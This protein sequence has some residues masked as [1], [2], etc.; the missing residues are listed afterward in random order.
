MERQPVEKITVEQVSIRVMSMEKTWGVRFAFTLEAPRSLASLAPFIVWLRIANPY[1]KAEIHWWN[2]MLC[3][4]EP[5]S[6]LD[7]MHI[8]WTMLN[9]ADEILEAGDTE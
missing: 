5:N 1:H 8:M 7:Y 2:D 3:V 4:P 6:H 9:M